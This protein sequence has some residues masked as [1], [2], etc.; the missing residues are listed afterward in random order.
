MNSTFNPQ[1]MSESIISSGPGL[2][3]IDGFHRNFVFNSKRMARPDLQEARMRARRAKEVP[4]TINIY[5]LLR[6]S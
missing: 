4:L 5:S 1:D 3:I 6:D 2:R